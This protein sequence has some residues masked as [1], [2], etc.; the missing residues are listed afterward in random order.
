M[1]NDNPA[2][3][4][5]EN[6]PC[7]RT[8][9]GNNSFSRFSKRNENCPMECVPFAWCYPLQLPEGMPPSKLLKNILNIK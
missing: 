9:S 6:E 3:S 2:T 5:R 4:Q 7:S 1:N 8:Q